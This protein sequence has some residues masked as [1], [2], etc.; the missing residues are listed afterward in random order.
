MSLKPIAGYYKKEIYISTNT[1][2]KLI[3]KKIREDMLQISRMKDS[4]DLQTLIFCLLLDY[5]IFH[6]IFIVDLLT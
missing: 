2:A 3:E 5:L 6:F 4:G 1:I